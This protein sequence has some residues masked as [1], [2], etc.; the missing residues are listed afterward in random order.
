MSDQSSLFLGLLD[1]R[2]DAANQYSFARGHRSYR[3]VLF[4]RLGEGSNNYRWQNL[5]LG[6]PSNSNIYCC[7]YLASITMLR[8]ALVYVYSERV[9]AQL[10]F[11]NYGG[12]ICEDLHGNA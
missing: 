7:M 10:H 1:I 8:I 5:V 11:M 3:T 12:I 6:N 4:R 9:S 2:V